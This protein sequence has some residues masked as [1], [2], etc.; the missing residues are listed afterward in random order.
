MGALLPGIYRDKGFLHPGPC[1]IKYGEGSVQWE[2][3]GTEKLKNSPTSL[4]LAE[5]SFLSLLLVP[6]VTFPQ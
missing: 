3:L 5:S 6:E 4:D 2:Y 1:A